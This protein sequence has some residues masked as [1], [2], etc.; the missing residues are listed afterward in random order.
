MNSTQPE[1]PRWL[2][3][4]FSGEDNDN[5]IEV[6]YKWRK[7]SRSASEGGACVE[8]APSPATVLVRD[9]KV[10]DG[11][12]LTLAPAAWAAFTRSL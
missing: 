11:P 3:S 1:L 6:A 9:S 2:K 10:P 12:N 8:V 5:C 7:S 4:S